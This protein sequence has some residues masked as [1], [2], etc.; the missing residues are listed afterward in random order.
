MIDLDRMDDQLRAALVEDPVRRPPPDPL[1]PAPPRARRPRRPDPPPAGVRDLL[2]LGR[3]A[4]ADE[5][6]AAATGPLDQATWATMR[7][8]LDG[9]HDA[10]RL[11]IDALAR[12]AGDGHAE[13]GDRAWSLRFWAAREWGTDVERLDA[14]DHC[15]ER[16]YRYDEL[17]WWGNLTLLLAEMGKSD[18]AVRAFDQT[19][20]LVGAA[21]RD[22]R[23]VDVVTNLIE[24][25]AQLG[26]AGRTALAGRE[27][28]V[29]T[30]RLVVV[31]DAV[32]CKG[33]VDR[34]LGLL[35]AAVGRRAEAGEWFGRAE[36]T[37]RAMGAGPLLARTVAQARGTPAAA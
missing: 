36:A 22:G 16:A 3:L 8:L 9:R 35:H 2:E 4:D 28:R 14:L 37:H 13:A 33:S 12:M 24:A 7:A 32:V 11:G 23:R 20:P 6:I 34:Y 25:G 27:L 30:G 17:S 29:E 15:R 18:E 19:L 5:R 21:P 26:D 1:P 10:V 31:G